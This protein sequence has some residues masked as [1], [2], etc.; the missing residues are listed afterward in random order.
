M[1]EP[2]RMRLKRQEKIADADWSFIHPILTW[3]LK[4]SCEAE[5]R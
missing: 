4:R 2:G 5:G 3:L 1:A